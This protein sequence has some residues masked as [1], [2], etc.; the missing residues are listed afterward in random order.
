MFLVKVGDHSVVYTVSG[1]DTVLF[2]EAREEGS[3]R[4]PNELSGSETWNEV[5]LTHLA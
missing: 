3:L 5:A 2:L 4:T 1:R